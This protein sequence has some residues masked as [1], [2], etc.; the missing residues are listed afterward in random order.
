M[1]FGSVGGTPATDWFPA[2]ALF[3]AATVWFPVLA[4]FAGAAGVGVEEGGAAFGLDGVP[5]ADAA[6][7]LPALVVVSLACELELPALL[8]EPFEV[9]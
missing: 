8:A 9:V 4:L 6:G 3:A 5:L 7:C 2:P 1:A